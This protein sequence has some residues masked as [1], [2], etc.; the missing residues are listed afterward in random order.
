MLHLAPANFTS[1]T[2]VLVGGFLPGGW[3]W[4][5]WGLA[6]AVHI[7]STLL[8][9]ISEFQLSP[10]HFVERHGLVLIVALG[11]SI[12]AIG[13]GA[14]GLDLDPTLIIVASLGLTIAYLLWWTYFAGDDNAAE[15]A[16]DAVDLRRRT[17]M[18]IR[19]YVYAYYFLLLGIVV[20][21]AGIKKATQY[22][23]GHLGPSYALLVPG[24]LTIFLLGD[25][26]FRRTLGFG[27]VRFRLVAA[28]VALA[29]APLGTVS[30]IAQL[31]VVIA[32]LLA[33]LVVE[34]RFET[35]HAVRASN[36]I[37]GVS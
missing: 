21:A 27:S 37:Y 8:R 14:A 35:R 26:A 31:A 12:V 30:T 19:A 29:T 6:F 15:D 18:A 2:L 23:D 11:E 20:V 24:G 17:R 3:R 25:V 7:A 34:Y 1:A 32:L 5:L 33:M 36:S 22:A 13:V 10:G 16:L 28:V 4:A 9:P